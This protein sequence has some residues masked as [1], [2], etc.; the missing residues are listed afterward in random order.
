MSHAELLEA[1][2]K[3]APHERAGMAR[4]LL[5]SLDDL[6]EVELNAL[7]A[8]EADRRDR[9]IDAGNLVSNPAIAVF[10][11]IKAKFA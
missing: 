6:S 9:A 7:W 8:D 4:C 5:E 11:A 3:L 2:L 10:D 1:V